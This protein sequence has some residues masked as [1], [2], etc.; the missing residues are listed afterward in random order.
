LVLRLYISVALK[1]KTANVKVAFV[2]RAMQWIVL[3]EETAKESTRRMKMMME[4]N[5]ECI[6]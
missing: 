4:I 6:G 2:S 1:Q 5:G 3:T